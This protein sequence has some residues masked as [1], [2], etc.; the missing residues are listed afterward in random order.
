MYAQQC[1]TLCEPWTVAHQAPLSMEF[2]R[3]EYWSGLTFPIPR[4]SSWFRDQ[5]CVLGLLHW[6]A[7]SLQLRN[8]GS[9]KALVSMCV[10]V[11]VF[12]FSHVWLFVTHELYPTRFLCPWKF[13]GKNTGVGCYFLLE[14][15]FLTP[16]S[17]SYL[18]HLLHWLA[19]SL[20]QAPPQKPALACNLEKD[21]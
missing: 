10:C 19:G 13:P 4:G 16:G 5:T 8:P 20:P 18:L 14:R 7:D 2:S 15:I 12:V 1:P 6:Q 17:N 9:P 11:C 3:Q 21:L